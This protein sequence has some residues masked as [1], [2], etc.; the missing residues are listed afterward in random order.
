MIRGPL[1]TF[2]AVSLL[3][4]PAIAQNMLSGLYISAAA[5][6]ATFWDVD[7]EGGGEIEFDILGFF[8]SGQMGFHLQPNFRLEAELSFESTDVKN[9]NID[10]EVTRGTLSGYYEFQERKFFGFSDV[11]PYAGAGAGIAN[12][13][14]GAIDEN[15]I[16]W[17]AEGGMSISHQ[18]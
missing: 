2:L 7:V 14:I 13:E 1:I 16:T 3:S 9:S 18:R 11:R 5:G 12:V 10:A 17:H 15:E 6:Q 8:L 4:G